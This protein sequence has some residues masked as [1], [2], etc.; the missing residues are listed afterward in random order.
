MANGQGLNRLTA[1]AVQNLNEPGWHHDGGGLYLEIAGS[2]RKRWALR[3]TAKGKTRDFGLGPLHKVSLKDAREAAAEYRA[4]LY[5][6]I[7]PIAEK[8]VAK[9]APAAAPTFKVCTGHVYE[10]RKGQLR[11]GKHVEQW[12]NQL[13][14][15]AFPVIGDKSIDQ[16][17]T[18]DA[19]AVL[20]P[21][22]GTKPDTARRI[23]QRLH[24]I[25]DW[26]RAA[27]H[28]SG[29][30]PVDLIGEALPKQKRTKRHFTAL[31]NKRREQTFEDDEIA[32][33]ID[34]A[35]R[36]AEMRDLVLDAVDDLR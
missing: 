8:R 17:T 22:W 20:T 33:L 36:A 24:T 13:E 26:A 15:H 23:R 18:A 19:L 32:A 6:G 27:G 9:V 2:G 31:L 21:I 10:L 14:D 3:V 12:Y 7:D 34:L 35:R 4:K 1:L 5:K 29:D 25:L 16:I 28:R 30:N 11:P